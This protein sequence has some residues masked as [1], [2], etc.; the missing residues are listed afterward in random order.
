MTR[1]TIG[2][3]RPECSH[4][5]SWG[6]AHIGHALWKVGRHHS[7]A[8]RLELTPSEREWFYTNQRMSA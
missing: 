5:A 3:T 1:D 2:L 7:A 6:A 8:V 4:I